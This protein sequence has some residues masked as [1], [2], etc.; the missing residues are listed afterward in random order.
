MQDTHTCSRH[1]PAG[2]A[3]T[4]ASDAASEADALFV[5]A[6][7]DIAGIVI[8]TLAGVAVLGAAAFLIA[9]RVRRRRREGRLI[10][11]DNKHSSFE[12]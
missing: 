2:T 5:C 11:L 1:I 3:G 12:K 6:G 10:T 4:D 8:G 7:G 9:R